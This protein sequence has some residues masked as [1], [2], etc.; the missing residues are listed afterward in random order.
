MNI[1]CPRVSVVMSVYNGESFLLRAVDSILAQTFGDFEFIVIN[2]GSTDGTRDIL[3][4]CDD[5]RLRVVHQENIGL[6]C[7]LNKGIRLARGEYIARMDADDVSLPDR[8]AREVEA[9]D[10]DDEIGVVDA[11]ARWVGDGKDE[12]LRRSEAFACMPAALLCSNPITHGNAMIRKRALLDVGGYDEF[13]RYSQDHDLWLRM[14]WTG[15][16][17]HL[18]PE[19][20]YEFRNHA[21][22]ITQSKQDQ[23]LAF[24][25]E[26]RLRIIR[27]IRGGKYE[28]PPSMRDPL[29][30][31]LVYVAGRW[32]K[33]GFP[34]DAREAVR[35]HLKLSPSS[36]T[37]YK[38]LLRSHDF[39]RRWYD[40]AARLKSGL[41]PTG[42]KGS[43]PVRGRNR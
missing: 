17:F 21:A 39:I 11:A 19:V 14:A 24:S 16:R 23:Q 8:L 40:V 13:F 28:L 9:L 33:L 37:G 4:S 7:S 30:D 36:L 6:T 25:R 29:S 38:I 20:L 31:A 26:A 5:A 43:Q 27:G 2:D 18:V 10:R 34:R 22:S 32:L 35:L 42:G 3:E 12:V 15:H 1:P 41:R